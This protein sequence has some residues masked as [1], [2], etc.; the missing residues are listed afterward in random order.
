MSESGHSTPALGTTLRW[1]LALGWRTR[2]ALVQL[3]VASTLLASLLPAVATLPVGFVVAAVY[4]AVRDSSEAPDVG[5]AARWVVGRGGVVVVEGAAAAGR[6]DAEQRLGDV[7]ELELSSRI[8]DHAATLELAFFEDP[9]SQ[10]VLSRATHDPGGAFLRFF[11]AAASATGSAVLCVAL[12]IVLLWVDWLAAPALVML[13]APFV[14]HHWRLGRERWALERTRT[15]RQRWAGYYLGLVT[16]RET[17]PQTRMLG[18]APLLAARYRERIAGIH[19]ELAALYAR[20]ARGRILGYG[21]YLVGLAGAVAWVATRA[22]AGTIDLAGL[23]TFT[24]AGVRLRT[25]VSDFASEIGAARESSLFLSYLTEFLERRPAIGSRAGAGGAVDREPAAPL[26]SPAPRPRPQATSTLG[27][28]TAAARVELDRLSFT[29]PGDSHPALDEVSL[30]IEPGTMAALVGHNGSGKTTLAKL[31]AGLYH[32]TA[33]A[34]LVDGRPLATIEPDDWY[35]RVALVPQH[36]VA[37]EAS[38]HENIALG[39]WR[40]LL[41]DRERVERIAHEAGLEAVARSLPQGL[42]TPLG[43]AFGAADLSAGQWQRVAIARALAHDPGL[44]I[45]DEPTANL[46]AEAEAQVYAAVRELARDRTTLV[47][48]HRFS[49]VRR[50]DRVFVLEAGRLVESG[51]HAA[52]LVANGLYAR[53][54]RLHQGETAAEPSDEVAAAAA[55]E[56]RRWTTPR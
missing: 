38:L 40:A 48:S 51:T 49:T 8:L 52:L 10:D 34:I 5:A 2:P 32:P 3:L 36:P 26:D 1:A 41:D 16:R 33:G 37:Y 27:N 31:L 25:A 17:V 22:R 50:A 56:P 42:D 47:I 44:L 24:L 43:R 28:R 29:Y 18:L 35:R 53:L 11:E 6:R 30:S 46:D 7:L 23:A 45:L 19:G 21:A 14:V 15:R 55:S 20:Q 13:A 9:D 39:D 12:V 4:R 54:Y